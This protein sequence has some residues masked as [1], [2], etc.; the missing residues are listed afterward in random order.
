MVMTYRQRLGNYL[1]ALA[2]AHQALPELALP[3]QLAFERQQ[4]LHQQQGLL[5]ICLCRLVLQMTQAVALVAR[6]QF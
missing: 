3:H 6:K 1:A 2:L 5:V 4:G